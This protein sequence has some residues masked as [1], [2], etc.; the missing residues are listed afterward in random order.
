MNAS[1]RTDVVKTSNTLCIDNT[2][3]ANLG[4]RRGMFLTMSSCG[5]GTDCADEAEQDK[6]FNKLSYS[7]FFIER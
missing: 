6:I 3:F 7:M 2:K 5:T 4:N 1:S